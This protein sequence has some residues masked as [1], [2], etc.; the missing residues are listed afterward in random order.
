MGIQI[1]KYWEILEAY[2]IYVNKK[3]DCM[4]ITI[5]NIIYHD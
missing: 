3:C 2:I 1:E 5:Y 4:I